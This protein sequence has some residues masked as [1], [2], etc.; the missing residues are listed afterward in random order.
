MSLLY[1]KQYKNDLVI[2]FLQIDC[3][4]TMK[5]FLMSQNDGVL[6]IWKAERGS[7][8]NLETSL[9]YGHVCVGYRVKKRKIKDT[10]ITWSTKV[11]QTGIEKSW[12]MGRFIYESESHKGN[13]FG[14]ASAASTCSRNEMP[15][16]I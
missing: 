10:L 14:F 2:F 9:K 3:I 12:K 16:K 4:T 8:K 6:C 15:I 5:W 7:C 1:D 11:Y 13:N